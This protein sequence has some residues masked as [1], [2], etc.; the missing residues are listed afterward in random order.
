MTTNVKEFNA[1]IGEFAK[2]L[3]V[4]HVVPFHKKIALE[5]LRRIVLRTPVDTGRARGNWQLTID[6][7]ATG[8]VAN[9]DKAGGGTIAAGI[10]NIGGLRPFTVVYL[11]NNVPYAEALENGHSKG[12]APNGMVA[13]TFAELEKVIRS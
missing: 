8:E 6:V 3:P 10:G 13:V 7:P 11:T 2:K 1:A 9:L 5:C 12:Q 4:E